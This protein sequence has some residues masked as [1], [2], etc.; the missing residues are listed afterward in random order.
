M[1]I[2][3]T[4]C[5]ADNR[6]AAKFCSVC[7]GQLSSP[8]QS[9]PGSKPPP[10]RR[11]PPKPSQQSPPAQSQSNLPVPSPKRQLPTQPGSSPPAQSQAA[12]KAGFFKSAPEVDGKVTDVSPERQEKPPFDPARAIVMLSVL[13]FMLAGFAIGAAFSLALWIALLIVGI[14]S[15]GCLFPVLIAPIYFIIGPIIRWI[16]GEQSILVL[17]FQVLDN[18]SG[19]PVDVVLYRKPGGGN[20]RQGDVVKVYGDVQR[21]SNIVHAHK[22]Q[23]YESRGRPTDYS[24]QAMRPWPIWIGLLALGGTVAIL[25]YLVNYLGL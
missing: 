18:L 13:I 14:G 5:G 21:G 19:Q 11:K 4:D 8:Q 20:V 24:I 9:P 1:T 23:V 15:L 22:V 16:R 10:S 12:S 7:G 3:C 17:N 2:R 6:D 25:W